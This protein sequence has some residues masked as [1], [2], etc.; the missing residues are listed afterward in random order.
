[1]GA[2]GADGFVLS[3]SPLVWCYE[4]SAAG[5]YRAGRVTA[6]VGLSAGRGQYDH[7]QWARAQFREEQRLA[8]VQAAA[9]K[10]EER[11]QRAQQ[12]EAGRTEAAQRTNNLTE[13][14]VRLESILDMGLD[15]AARIDLR[16][17]MRHA[18]PAKLDLGEWTVASPPP[19]WA[20]FTP[21]EPGTLASMFGGRGRY[22]RQLAIARKEFDQAQRVHGHNEAVRRE[23]VRDQ[24]ARHEASVQAH[25]E[26][27]ARHNRDVESMQTGLRDRSPAHVQAYLE[28]VLARTPLPADLPRTVEVAYTPRGEQAV[29]RFELP[30]VE[31]VPTDVSYT[32]VGTTGTFRM[33]ARSKTEVAQ[34]YRSVVSQVTLLY[35][36]DLFEADAAL[37]NVELSGH[38][39]ATN[40]A[41]GQREYPC[42]ISVAVDR[43]AYDKLNLRSVTPDRCLRHLNA[44]VSHHPHLVEPVTPVRD[45]DLARY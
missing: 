34:L 42:L 37:E 8:K 31:V 19:E 25:L 24:R 10:A 22:E 36:R 3:A 28:L 40:P 18:A 29:V 15:R 26:E 21:P 1:M 45:F 41:T 17:V 43:A 20:D 33:K 35:T 32:Y 7:E 4:L 30:S 27:V 13:R 39:H 16:T 14:V 11:E 2:C 9:Q 44:L 23:W 6:G 38:V 12:L 5:A